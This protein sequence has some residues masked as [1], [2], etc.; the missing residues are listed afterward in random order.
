MSKQ[1]A[2]KNG[3]KLICRFSNLKLKGVSKGIYLVKINT[4][5][6]NIVK[7]LIVE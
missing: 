6:D 1:V 7:K 3:Q 5:E 2:A 4:K